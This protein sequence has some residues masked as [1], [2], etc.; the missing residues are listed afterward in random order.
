MTSKSSNP[1]IDYSEEKELETLSE[2][3]MTAKEID[4]KP[5]LILSY[6]FL[7]KYGLIRID[8]FLKNRKNKLG[9]KLDNLCLNE[10]AIFLYAMH[11]IDDKEFTQINQIQKIK[12]RITRPKGT[13]TTPYFGNK[14]NKK[15]SLI[16]EN[17]NKI[18]QSL[19]SDY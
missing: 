6:F 19:K 5:A 16:V 4:W 14:A 2:M 17:A 12:N 18:I 8:E 1:K 13:K 10:I 15:Y 7:K 3:A 9:K 11:Q